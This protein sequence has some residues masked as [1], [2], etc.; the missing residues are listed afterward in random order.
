MRVVHIL[1][2]FAAGVIGVTAEIV[3]SSAPS[4]DPS[5]V[6]MWFVGCGVF[7]LLGTLWYKHRVKATNRLREALAAGEPLR[8]VEVT[9]FTI[10]HVIPFGYEVDMQIAVVD[11]IPTHLGFGFW[12]RASA[13][14]LLA[15]L[16]PNV[17]APRVAP[18]IPRAKIVS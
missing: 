10:G 16:Q 9:R 2:L 17:V 7:T 13:E 15:L 5:K 8:N 1:C 11:A 6:V 3:S 4:R 18:K 14:R 12:R